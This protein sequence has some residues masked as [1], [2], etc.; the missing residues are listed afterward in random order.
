MKNPLLKALTDKQIEAVKTYQVTDDKGTRTVTRELAKFEIGDTV[1]VH[2]RILEGAK[3]RIQIFQGVVIARKGEGLQEM[4]TVR[5][6]V[7]GEGVERVFPLHSPK[8]AKIEVKRT[9]EVRRAKL[10][11]LR[12]RVGKAT[13]LRERKVKEVFVPGAPTETRG[14]GKKKK[15][16]ETQA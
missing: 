16:P 7:Q 9:G 3:E 1:D 4:F 12:D 5:R 15:T 10:Y 6:I 2:Q 13:R 14:K 8:I 11:Y